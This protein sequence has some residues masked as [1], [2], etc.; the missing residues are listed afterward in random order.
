LS[1]ILYITYDGLLEPLGSSQVLPYVLELAALGFEIEIL[2]FEKEFPENEIREMSER[3]SRHGVAWAP[4]QYHNRPSLTATIFDLAVGASHAFRRAKQ[5][6]GVIIHARSYLPALMALPAKKL[7]ARLLFDTRGLWVDE[8]IES[9]RWKRNSFVVRLARMAEKACVREADSF[10]HLTSKTQEGLAKNV[11]DVELAPYS[12]IPTCADLERFTPPEDLQSAREIV[13]LPNVPT[14]V[15]SGTISGWYLSD[16]TFQVGA[17]FVKQTGG[18]FLVLTREEE[19][20]RELSSRHGV[21]AVI[22]SVRPSEMGDWLRACDAGIALVRPSFAK[23]ASCPTK[24]GEYL[25]VGLAVAVTGGVGDLEEQLGASNVAAVVSESDGAA[26]I[27]ENLIQ[28]IGSTGR[29]PEARAISEKIWDLHRG[30]E[31]YQGIY[32]DLSSASS[33]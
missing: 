31:K 29:V 3:L 25:G 16:L 30:V 27:V 24:V 14:L 20:A 33:C 13:G 2:S 8:R 6:Q 11:P 10:V 12:V 32:R 23:T 21:D 7:G 22:R 26:S 17:E 9:G 19:L 5:S 15:H 18:T 4:L 1:S 28:K